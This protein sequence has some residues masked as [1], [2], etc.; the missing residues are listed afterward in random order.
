[1][2]SITPILKTL[3]KHKK[4]ERGSLENV[5]EISRYTEGI[6]YTYEYWYKAFLCVK[7]LTPVVRISNDIVICQLYI[8]ICKEGT[9]TYTPSKR[10]KMNI[11]RLRMN[12]NKK[13][14]RKQIND[15]INDV[16]N[17][18]Y[19]INDII[20]NN[21]ESYVD[22]VTCTICTMHKK[23]ICC[24]PCGHM[25]CGQCSKRLKD[26]CFICKRPINKKIKTY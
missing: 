17:N 24:V 16:A 3:Y 20:I 8:Y 9:T 26:E 22:D 10:I 12:C 18:K 4:F 11:G 23:Q 25:F 14:T 5:E 21:E 2:S 13:I 6:Y 1:M 15:Y 19:Q 7:I